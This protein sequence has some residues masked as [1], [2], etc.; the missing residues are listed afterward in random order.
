MRFNDIDRLTF[1]QTDNKFVFIFRAQF[2][3]GGL[4][5]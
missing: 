2:M 3:N 5:F 4:S 1:F